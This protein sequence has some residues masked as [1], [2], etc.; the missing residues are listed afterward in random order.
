V[1]TVEKL[2]C[3]HSGIFVGKKIIDQSDSHHQIVIAW[4]DLY[5]YETKND[6]NIK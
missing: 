4:Q 5:F 2:K 1:D 6:N 3:V